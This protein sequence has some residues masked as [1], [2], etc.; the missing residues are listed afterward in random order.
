MTTTRPSTGPSDRSVSSLVSALVAAGLI[1]A[2]RADEASA[3]LLDAL[4]RDRATVAPVRRRLAEVAG[5][6]GGA[7]VLAAVVVFVTQEWANLSLAQRVGGLVL[8]AVALAGGAVA[9]LIVGG[10]RTAD[11]LET[12]RG[13]LASTLFCAS[14]VTAAVAVGELGADRL[15]EEGGGWVV[16]AAAS[17]AMVLGLVFY[18]VLP[19][20]LNQLLIAGAAFAAIPSGLDVY[21][22]PGLDMLAFSLVVLGLGTFWLV[23]AETG[24]WRERTTGRFIGLG[25]VLLGAQLA[26][27]EED[28]AWVAYLLTALAGAAAVAM[29]VVLRSTPYLVAG[30]V[31]VTLVVP[32]AVLDWTEG[33]LGPV[34]ILLVAGVTLIVTSLA[35]LRLRQEVK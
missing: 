26:L 21:G 2:A 9:L 23:L 24:V 18:L 7:L 11:P 20:L 16:L 17:T 4:D 22:E 32:E 27:G 8:A 28:I 1:D 33:L 14:A 25:L 12:L 30:V 34:G 15:D 3:V 13:R 10:A 5:Y 29:Y 19:S 35:G 31:A 6:V